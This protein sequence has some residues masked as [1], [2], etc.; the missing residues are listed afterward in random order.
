[1]TKP[2]SLRQLAEML[3][4]DCRFSTDN[5]QALDRIAECIQQYIDN[6]VPAQPEQEPVIFCMHWEDRWGVNHYVD[7]KEPH[8]AQAKPLYTNPPAAAQPAQQEPYGWVQPNPSFNSGVFNLGSACP[9]G[10]VGSAIDV[11]TTPPAQPAPV[12][13]GWKLVPVVATREIEDAIG[14]ARNLKASEIWEDAL[15]ATPPAAQRKP[16]TDGK[17]QAIHDTYYRRMGPQEFARAI[18][19]A[20]GIK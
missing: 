5:Q 2:V 8:P 7:P 16:L 6:L 14:K 15:A 13:E 10:W 9:S 20:H 4:F 3:L 12:Q 17:I 19:A 11:Y 18:E 1:M